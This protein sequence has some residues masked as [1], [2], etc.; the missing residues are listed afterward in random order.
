A[1]QNS[2]GGATQGNCPQLP[3][4][5]LPRAPPRSAGPWE[6]V[7]GG[8]GVSRLA[9]VAADR[10]EQSQARGLNAV[11]AYDRETLL[12]QAKARAASGG[13]GLLEQVPVAVKDNICTLEYPTTCASRIL[14]GYRSPY[15]AT[16]IARLKGAGALIACKTNLDE[17]AMGAS[18]EYSAFG[19]ARHPLDPDRVP[20]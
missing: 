3:G 11:L 17:F 16:A 4:W 9:T 20:G 15:E 12:S 1:T 2:T 8:S 19:R 14:E 10:I 5:T 18:T 13:S 6:R 7:P